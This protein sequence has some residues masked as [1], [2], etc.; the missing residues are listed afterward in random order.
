MSKS[1]SSPG[2]SAA[3][4]ATE[5]LE[6]HSTL[7]SATLEK[8]REEMWSD[9]EIIA[10]REEHLSSSIFSTLGSYAPLAVIPRAFQVLR[11]S[12]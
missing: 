2:R 3:V 7:A 5:I 8:I 10:D 1:K 11:K 9:I 6:I 12:S 4:P